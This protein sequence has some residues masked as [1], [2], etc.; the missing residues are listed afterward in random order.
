MLGIGDAMDMSLHPLGP[1]TWRAQ[2]PRA[3]AD[4]C[5]QRTRFDQGRCIFKQICPTFLRWRNFRS[6]SRDRDP[7]AVREG[8]DR[9]TEFLAALHEVRHRD[10]REPFARVHLGVVRRPYQ[11]TLVAVR[12][13]GA[14]GR[15]DP[16][17]Y[18]LDRSKE[19]DSCLQRPALAE[20]LLEDCLL[21]T[22]PSPRD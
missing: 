21:Y 7:E 11:H 9:G 3:D 17:A 16:G 10:R 19:P 15:A 14:H 4:R 13:E 18:A 1:T 2:K 22:S 6:R 5:C 12:L 20:V 8:T